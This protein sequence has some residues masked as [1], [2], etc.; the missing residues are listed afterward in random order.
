MSSRLAEAGQ[1]VIQA[2]S[3]SSDKSGQ[4]EDGL[5]HG[6]LVLAPTLLRGS[7]DLQ[8]VMRLTK[9]SF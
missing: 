4:V 6:H 5:L 2:R 7:D 1:K 9:K 3:P 8:V